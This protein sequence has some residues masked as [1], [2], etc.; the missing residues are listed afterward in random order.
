MKVMIVIF[1]RIPAIHDAK[2]HQN[3]LIH[4]VSKIEGHFFDN[5][6]RDGKSGVK[7]E[8]CPLVAELKLKMSHDA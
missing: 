7:V 3:L 5:M 4:D 6:S 2:F 8:K 1:L